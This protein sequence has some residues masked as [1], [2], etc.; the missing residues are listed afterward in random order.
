MREDDRGEGD[1]KSGNSGGLVGLTG[2]GAVMAAVRN[3]LVTTAILTF[4]ADGLSQ[5]WMGKAATC[6]STCF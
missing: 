6:L 4:E 1:S 3:A 5:G 2:G